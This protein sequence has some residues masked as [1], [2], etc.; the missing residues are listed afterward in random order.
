MG[1]QQVDVAIEQYIAMRDKKTEIKDRHKVE[2]APVQQI[3]DRLEAWLLHHLNS[4]GAKSV[5]ADQGGTAFKK[6]RVSIT[7]QDREAF[8][9]FA[10]NNDELG[11][12]DIRA[13]KLA[14]EEFLEANGELPPGT[15]IVREI[16]AQVRR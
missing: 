1:R 10:V 9:E 12:L 7:V 13:S 15:S 11:L 3:M 16:V 2:L 8:M 6:K 14:V 5:T 4:T